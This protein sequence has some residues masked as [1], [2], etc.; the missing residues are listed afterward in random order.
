[1]NL[2]IDITEKTAA[3]IR[4]RAAKN[5]RKVADYITSLV[6]DDLTWDELVRPI[7]D[8]TKRLGLT[9]A[10]IEGLVDH[11]ISELRKERPLHTR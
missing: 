1:M 8:E 5:G 9:E 3:K 7:H 2:T 4:E 6:D 10:D 11:E